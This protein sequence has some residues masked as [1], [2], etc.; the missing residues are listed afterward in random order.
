MKIKAELQFM[1]YPNK[2]I[3]KDSISA[4]VMCTR[5]EA[6]DLYIYVSFI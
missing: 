1:K 5:T 4:S 6:A 2:L 3:V